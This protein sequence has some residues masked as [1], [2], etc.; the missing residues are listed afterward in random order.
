MAG[1]KVFTANGTFTP[2]TGRTYK[3]IA[4]GGGQALQVLG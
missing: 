1:M 3:V 4:I 2:V